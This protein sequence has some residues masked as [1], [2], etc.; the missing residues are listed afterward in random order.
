MK[1]RLLLFA[2]PCLGVSLSCGGGPPPPTDEVRTPTIK[3]AEDA[4]VARGPVELRPFDLVPERTI[5]LNAD[6][7]DE[8]LV[9]SL[10]GEA[11]VLNKML[12][13]ARGQVLV[14][15]GFTTL[16]LAGKGKVLVAR[17]TPEKCTEQPERTAKVVSGTELTFAGGTMYA[18]L[19][20]EGSD[21]KQAYLGYLS[22][23]GKVAEHV[24]E[25]SWEVLYAEN[26]TGTFT[27]RGVPQRLQKG[28]TVFVPPNTPHSWTPDPGSTLEAIQLYVP[29]GPEQRFKALAALDADAGAKQ[30]PV[31]A[32]TDA[33]AVSAKIETK[34]D[35][36]SDP[37]KTPSDGK[38]RPK[39]SAH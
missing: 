4:S 20:V 11:S 38:V 7:C 35:P 22:G 27:L 25:S 32:G 15:R 30:G 31:D 34:A 37:K 1:A 6:R 29:P 33:K 10:G 2:L 16:D 28:E 5:A 19:A 24:H 36:K 9:A 3:V 18:R 8:M 14:M 12:K 39:D 17:V 26:A 23:T 13:V 21:A